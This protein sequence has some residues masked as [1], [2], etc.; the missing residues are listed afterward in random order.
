[1]LRI[2]KQRIKLLGL[3]RRKNQAVRPHYDPIEEARKRAEFQASL[4]ET[5]R[6][7]FGNRDLNTEAA[8]AASG[9]QHEDV[10]VQQS[11]PRSSPTKH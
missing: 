10:M 9:P 5:Y 3:D 7:V 1:M 6:R 2:S 4:E 8:L 11:S